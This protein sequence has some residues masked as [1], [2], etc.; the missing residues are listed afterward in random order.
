MSP[1]GDAAEV[2]SLARAV[3]PGSD[4]DEELVRQLAFQA[5]GDLAPLN[6]FIGGVAA[7]E[8]MKAVSGKFTPIQQ[9]LYFDA[10]ECL[11]E[12]NREQ[13]LTEETCRPRG[14]RY[15]GQVAVFG[16]GLQERLGQ[17]KY[18]V[19][20]AGAIGCE[21][22]KTFAMMGLGCG[23]DGGVTVTDMDTIEKSNLNRQ[24]LF[25]PWDVTKLKSERAAAAAR[26]MNPALRVIGRSERVGPETER[27]FDDEFFEGLD[28]VANAL[29]NVDARG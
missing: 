7:Q 11:P 18:F 1:Q 22:L 19:V 6:G 20:G 12:E 4:L 3:S 10:L 26:E 16:T 23:P 14:N 24:F 28:G 9:W 2:L 8:V 29:D 15:D 17:Q 5:T 13:L 25:R 21:L 27:V